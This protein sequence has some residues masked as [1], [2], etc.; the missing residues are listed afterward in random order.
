MMNDTRVM[1]MEEL[2]PFLNSSGS[3]KFNGYSRT[4][5][6]AWIEKTLRQYKYL[7]RSRME[8]GHLRQYL[9]KVSGYSP[10]QLTRLIDQ[11]QCTTHLCVRPY[12]RHC[13]PTKFTREDQLLLAEVDEAHER[14]SGPATRRS[15]NE[16]TSYLLTRSSNG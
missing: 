1:S 9:R 10:A 15:L 7:A 6:Y 8:K 16:N 5:T 14:P 12:R 11:F 4:E 13:F 2:Q 3:L